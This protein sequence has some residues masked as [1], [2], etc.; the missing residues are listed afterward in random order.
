M[1]QAIKAEDFEIVE[2]N[3]DV[4]LT[5]I[6]RNNISNEF[7]FGDVLTHQ[8]DL[9]KMQTELDAQARLAEATVDNITRNH[10]WLT[11]LD[12]EKLHHAWMLFENKDVAKQS[13]EKLLQVEEQLTRYA[14]LLEVLAN[15]FDIREQSESTEA[16][17]TDRPTE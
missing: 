8:R 11:E 6:K 16:E 4:R 10:E 5:L 2:T 9:E 12:D 1:S 7:T 17:S 15:N 13:R 14:D 3:D